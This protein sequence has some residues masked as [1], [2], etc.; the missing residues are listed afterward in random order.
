MSVRIGYQN[1]FETAGAVVSATSEATGYPKENAFDWL[2]F[3][4]WKA[5]AAGTVYLTVDLLAAKSVDYFGLYAHD[6]HN[7]SGTVQLQW[8]TDNFA[9]SINN[10]GTNHTPT[11]DRPIF[12]SFTSQSAR[13]WRLKIVSTGSASAIG[14]AS[15]GAMLDVGDAPQIGFI[16]PL[17][18]GHKA[19]ASTSVDGTFIGRTVREH[20][21]DIRISFKYLTPAWIRSTWLPFHEHAK[22]KPFFVSWDEVNY[23]SEAAFCWIEKESDMKVP[24]YSTAVHMDISIRARAEV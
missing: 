21:S 24:K 12:E 13:Y 14:C 18:R 9:A 16:P 2:P 1:L 20:A 22:T 7:N 15:F 11:D 10:I 5:A 4:A 19:I 23:S 6:L 8:S 17:S 3:D